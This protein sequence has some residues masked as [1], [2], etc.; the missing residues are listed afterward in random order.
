MCNDTLMSQEDFVITQALLLY[1]EVT[2]KKI[3]EKLVL[4]FMPCQF[5]MSKLS[6][7]RMWR[8]MED[9]IMRGFILNTTEIVPCWR[10]HAGLS[11]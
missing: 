4:Y 10:A 11:L 8:C 2:N 7:I 1:N 3:K 9:D 5:N 6:Y